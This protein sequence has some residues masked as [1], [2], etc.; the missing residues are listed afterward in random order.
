[1]R[2]NECLV[3]AE[4]FHQTSKSRD[5]GIVAVKRHRKPRS[6]QRRSRSAVEHRR[7]RK[8]EVDFSGCENEGE[9]RKRLDAFWAAEDTGLLS[10]K[11]K[12]S[13][14]AKTLPTPEATPER[15]VQSSR[16]RFSEPTVVVQDAIGCLPNVPYEI[17]YTSPN[18]PNVR[19]LGTPESMEDRIGV[20]RGA[21]GH[22]VEI[23]Q[24]NVEDLLKGLLLD[25][26]DA[27]PESTSKSQQRAR[28]AEERRLKAIAEAAKKRKELRLNRRHPLRALVQPL[29]SK[30][31]IMVHNAYETRD[32]TQVLT[33]SME[34]TELRQKDFRTLL[35]RH[36]W[37]NDEIINTYIEWIVKAANEAATAE[38][39]AAHEPVGTIPKFIA[40]NSFFYENLKKKGPSSTE[41][42]M[43][44]KKAP[45]TS[46]MEVDSIFVPICS[47]AHWTIGV[48]R[49]VA[50][51]IE[52]FDSMGGR[53][54]A[55]FGH[56]R[57]WLQ[58]QLK[59][60]YK[61]EEWTEP[62]TACAWQSNGYD[63]GVFVCTNAFCVAVGLDTSCYEESH[64]TE[65][66]KNIA[67][68]LINRGFT[69]DFSWSK[70]GLLPQ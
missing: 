8:L 37:L 45:G 59:G 5:D 4:E 29:V 17:E 34:G 68:V 2:L 33:T 6:E 64:M 26:E 67:A 47:G 41:R 57:Q 69:G 14:Q 66:R 25:T 50:K 11:E 12:T 52:Y 19:S 62:N 15:D 3:T 70:S 56:M 42:L 51:T 10:K 53:P 60:H 40:H 9:A 30:W 65:Q 38:S 63:C 20:F 27:L 32:P 39:K 23:K 21:P 58:F 55:F 28:L 22:L 48:V 18:R 36:A 43:K 46:L 13:V 61:A 7:V 44:R 16:R 35:G 49:P 1:L 31:D 24:G 54:A